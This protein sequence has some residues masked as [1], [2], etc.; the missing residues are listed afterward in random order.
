MGDWIHTDEKVQV[1]T[2]GDMV[3]T[4]EE[5]DGY[6]FWST[7]IGGRYVTGD[8]MGEYAYSET[9]AKMYAELNSI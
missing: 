1:K 7:Y 9:E 3:L 5:M 2:E 6:W 8:D 4:I